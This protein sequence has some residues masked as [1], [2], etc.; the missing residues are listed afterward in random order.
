MLP[1]VMA[2]INAAPINMVGHVLARS[3]SI[4]SKA[5]LQNALPANIKAIDT[6]STA[7]LTMITMRS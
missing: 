2:A 6:M 1:A 3:I 4:S 7:A 5:L